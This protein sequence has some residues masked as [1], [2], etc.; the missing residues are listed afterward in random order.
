MWDLVQSRMTL[1]HHVPQ[2]TRDRRL[3]SFN[4]ILAGLLALTCFCAPAQGSLDFVTFRT[5][6]NGPVLQTQTFTLPPS[7]SLR[8]STLNLA[9]LPP[10]SSDQG[11]RLIPF[12]SPWRAILASLNS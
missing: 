8:R 6:T 9:L 12:P 10:S 7:P 1:T 2:D 5:G 11:S 3:V 4:L